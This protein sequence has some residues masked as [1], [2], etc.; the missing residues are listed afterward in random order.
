MA[1]RPNLTVIFSTNDLHNINA[2]FDDAEYL[3][4]YNVNEETAEF[5]GAAQFDPKDATD[6]QLHDRCNMTKG[7]DILFV[8]APLGPRA[9]FHMVNTKVFAIKLDEPITIDQ[10]ILKTQ[11]M[12]KNKLPPWLRKRRE[13]ESETGYVE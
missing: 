1:K 12:L 5:V 13:T 6:V 9:A 4:V 8:N 11:D 7:A 10:A 2:K 3:S